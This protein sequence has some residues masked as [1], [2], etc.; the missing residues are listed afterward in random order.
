[1]LHILP[2]EE[3]REVEETGIIG[4]SA[5][6][7]AKIAKL[8]VFFFWKMKVD[9]RLSQLDIVRLLESFYEIFFRKMLEN[10]IRGIHYSLGRMQLLKLW[11]KN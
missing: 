9:E 8:K 7:K 1:M 10:L 5:F 11:L 2:G 3:K 4:K 6:Q